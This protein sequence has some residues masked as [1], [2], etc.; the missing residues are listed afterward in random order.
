M[1]L[2]GGG[3]PHAEW[4]SVVWASL[5]RVASYPL[6]NAPWSVE[7]MHAS[8]CAPTTTESPDS[9][10]RQHG[11]EGGVL[12]GVAVELL[13]ERLGVARSASSGTIRQASLPFAI[14]SSECW[15]QTT[16]T[17]SPRA[18]STRLAMFATTASRS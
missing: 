11:L 12:E 14:C 2:S 3:A 7:R 4:S 8:V 10:A 6:T 5:T 15:T 18:F 13:D 1:T 16:G 17:R 9:E